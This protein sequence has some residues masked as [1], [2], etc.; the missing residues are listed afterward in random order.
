LVDAYPFVRSG[1]TF[2]AMALTLVPQK[3]LRKAIYADQ[4]ED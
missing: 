4:K 3:G 2:E 1:L